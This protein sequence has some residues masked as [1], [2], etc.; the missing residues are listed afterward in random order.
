MNFS[1]LILL[2][3]YFMHAGHSAELTGVFMAAFNVFV[4]LTLPLC[5][6]VSD[7]V[8]RRLMF[9]AGAF[10]MAVPSAFYGLMPGSA[11]WPLALRSLQ[12]IGFS[13]AFGNVGAMA[14]DLRRGEDSTGAL[15]VLT[16]TGIVTHALGPLLGEV[17]VERWGFGALFMSASLFGTG[18]LVLSAFLREVPLVGKPRAFSFRGVKEG[19]MAASL[20]LGMMFGIVIV[21]VPPYLTLQVHVRS[22]TMF[23][24]LVAGTALV[25][26]VL[27]GIPRLWA[28]RAP[29]IAASFFMAVLPL[30][31]PWVALRFL[32]PILAVVFGVGYGYLYPRLNASMIMAAGGRT[33]FA[34]A[35][36]VWSFNVGMLVASLL[37]GFMIDALGYVH[38]FRIVGASCLVL[39]AILAPKASLSRG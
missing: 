12:G 24:S 15:A 28:G 23:L 2:P 13:L 17:L 33:G 8:S 25:W 32:G 5:A 39:L 10:L 14:A 35:L 27:V 29:W 36:F 19:G 18:A 26:A 1:E 16:L 9:G 37:A 3:V 34:N 4:V 38:T 7:M 6:C 30:C 31:A 20:V 22:G 11:A 21:F